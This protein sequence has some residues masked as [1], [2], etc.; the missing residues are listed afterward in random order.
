[1]LRWILIL[2]LVAAPLPT[3]AGT[4]PAAQAEAAEAQCCCCSEQVC[5][6]GCDAPTPADESGEP[7]PGP[8]FCGCDDTPL[9][10]PTAATSVP[11]LRVP[12]GTHA[13]ATLYPPGPV[14]GRRLVQ[15][16]NAPPAALASLATIILLN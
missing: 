15:R 6:C 4:A 5:Q 9:T 12:A 1:M 16:A 10:L 3:V 8:R 7:A 13:D 2:T 14:P 11:D